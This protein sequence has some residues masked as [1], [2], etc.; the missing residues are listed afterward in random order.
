[1]NNA[2]CPRRFNI[3]AVLVLLLMLPALAFARGT[4]WEQGDEFVR[5]SKQDDRDAP[6]NQHPAA[7]AASD[8][9]PA[10]QSLQMSDRKTG[11]HP[12]FGVEEVENLAQHLSV[13]LAEAKPNQDVVFRTLARY[14]LWGSDFAKRRAINTGRVFVQDGRVNIIFG[15]VQAAD[16]KRVFYGTRED[17]R[18]LHLGAREEMSPLKVTLLAEGP[19]SYGNYQGIRR[20]DWLVIDTNLQ[21]GTQVSTVPAAAVVARPA[22]APAPVPSSAAASAPAPTV[23][24]AAAAAP[25]PGGLEDRLRRLKRLHDQQLI[26]EDEYREK[27]RDLLRDL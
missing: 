18:E 3:S 5:L 13:A 6:P 17:W 23:A 27:V 25:A 2:A 12:V 7:Y 1:M 10:L 26:G 11:A 4:I 9:L 24:P 21:A 20:P 19:A 15:E 22:P 14:S 8:L 16:R